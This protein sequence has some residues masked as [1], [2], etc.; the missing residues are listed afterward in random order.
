MIFTVVTHYPNKS[1]LF[2][3]GSEVTRVN[4]DGYAN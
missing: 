1:R 4:T 3:P 2:Y